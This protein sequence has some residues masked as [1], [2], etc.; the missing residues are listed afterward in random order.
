MAQ[1]VKELFPS[2]RLTFGP[3]TDTGFY[4][5]FDY[6]RPFTPQDLDRIGDKVSKSSKKIFLLC[7]ERF[8]KKKL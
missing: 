4:Y 5:D 8:P 6:D 3:S 2:V 7:V 1:A